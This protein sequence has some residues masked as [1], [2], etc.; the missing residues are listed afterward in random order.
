[1]AASVRMAQPMARVPYRKESPIM[2][3]A[4]WINMILKLEAPEILAA[5][6][7]LLSRTVRTWDRITLAVS[8]HNNNAM[9]STMFQMLGPRKATRTITKG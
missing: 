3:G 9:A 1:M 8:R 5:S 4:M 6:T 7:K 2:F